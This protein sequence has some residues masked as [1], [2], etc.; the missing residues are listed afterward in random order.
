[1]SNP[2]SKLLSFFKTQISGAPIQHVEDAVKGI[3]EH[4]AAEVEAI[5]QRFEHRLAA[6]EVKL[7]I[8]PAP[9]TESPPPAAA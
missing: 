8:E 9:A 2:L 3:E 5:E 6:I 7:G 4:V 1:M